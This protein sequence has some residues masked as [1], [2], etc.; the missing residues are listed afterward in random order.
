[1]MYKCT[2]AFLIPEYDE[3]GAISEQEMII[4]KGTVWKLDDPNQNFI[5]GEIRLVNPI[6]RGWLEISEETLNEYFEEVLGDV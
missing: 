1:M 2:K 4:E 6:S 3:D 5:G